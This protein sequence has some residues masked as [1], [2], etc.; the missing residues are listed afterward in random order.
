MS[1]QSEASPETAPA[2]AS[3][4]GGEKLLIIDGHSMAFRAFYALPPESFLTDSGQY[5]NAVHGFTNMLLKLIREEEPTH[6]ALAFDLDTPTFR[7]T[8]YDEYKAGRAK[9]PEEFRGQIALIKQVAAAMNIPA[10]TV[11]GYEADD[12]V[13][14]C[15]T[16]AEQA[17]WETLI[18][19]GDRDALQLVT[20]RTTLMYPT[21]G[22]S[23][24]TLL[25][26][27]GVEAKYLVP[28]AKYPDLAALVGESADNLPGVPKVGPKTAA[29]WI[30]Q[31]GS[32]REIIAHAD[33][34]GGKVGEN[35]RAALDDV[36]RNLELNRLVQDLDLPVALQD[37]A[38]TLPDRD[39]VE[40]LFDALQFNQ[41]RERLF[42]TFAQRFPEAEIAA[43]PTEELP[44]LRVL[45]EAAELTEALDATEGPV[46]V[47]L[48]LDRSGEGLSTK[49]QRDEA[50]RVAEALAVVLVP[51][52]SAEALVI[53]LL[54][55]DSALETALGEWMAEAGRPKL[56]HDLKDAGRRLARRG[57]RLAGAA[58]DTLISGYLIQ[59]DRRSFAFAD[60]VTQYLGASTEPGD[61]LSESA[62][63]EVESSG[64]DTLFSAQDAV[65][66]VSRADL[67]A[68]AVHG[69]LLHRLS[70][71]LREQV[72]GR[73]ASALLHDLEIPLAEVLLQM[74]LTGIAVSR[75]RLEA[76]DAE[77]E[78]SIRAS[79]EAA[80]AAVGH[81]V[82]LGS[83]KQLQTVLFDELGLPKTRKTKTGYSTDVESLQDLL[84]KTQNE[85]L[86]HLMAHRDATKLR[87]TVTGLRGAVDDDGRIHT[88]YA[89][90]VAATGR[91]SSLHPNLQNIPVRTAAGRRIRDAF[92]VGEG[93]EELL[94][95]DYSQIEMRIMAHLS[96]DQA[97]ID[98]FRAGEDLH[99]FVGA[100]V[101][102]VGTEEVSTEMR[103]KVK[104]MSYGLVY[105]LSSFGLSKQ[106]GIG[107]DEARD[108][109]NEYFQRFGA[110]RDYLR[111][112]V[113]QA[114]TD[115]YTS[116]L[117]G[118]RRY[119]PDLTSD[120]RQ[121]RQMA[122]RAALNAPIQGSAADIIKRAMLD[123]DA[124]LREA[125]HDSR[126][127]LQVH[128]ELVLE[129]A[130][131]ERE[132]V[133]QLVVERMR[134][135][136]ELSVPLDV[137]VGVGA[138]WH[139]AAH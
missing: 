121:L 127:L 89:Q 105:G 42:E 116:T 51:E 80:Y 86:V 125:G 44:P 41:I 71:V 16:L 128:D 58:E 68:A 66:G 49:S 118:R 6:V 26:P 84:V 91:L 96:G 43:E 62:A 126:M 109:M 132:A 103:S 92:V 123:V 99:S 17:G 77:F 4:S 35:L 64:G 124:A 13:A 131:G 117:Y 130:S 5:T 29:K 28:P 110:V 120:N 90:T 122:E 85:F 10:I 104:A 50:A 88:T 24:V 79:A 93:H 25:D 45:S 55:A 87:Q 137:H 36:E 98:A 22:I 129:V 56:I 74:E 135:A 12:I 82:N 136:A 115:G 65:S 78:E 106:L 97:L 18:V 8:S 139:E 67:E 30:D 100:R 107:V 32:T 53:S 48:C 138:S 81:E 40:P 7:H 21:S 108:L 9:T 31:Y 72:A 61:Y 37:T 47:A 101:F 133:E 3:S 39:A 76:L 95:A 73:D 52:G 20:E 60:L 102:G 69:M 119:L 2:A 112:V 33:Q 11:E 14:T 23:K 70:A 1:Q 94:T 27:A 83:P 38:L 113:E 15:T 54:E 111:E 46:G 34:I 59:P 134:A 75:E 114:R 57:L 19:S 63:A